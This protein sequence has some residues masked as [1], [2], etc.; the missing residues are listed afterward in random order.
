M[1]NDIIILRREVSGNTRRYYRRIIST[2]YFFKPSY[3]RV[4]YYV[5]PYAQILVCY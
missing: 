4:S 2:F 1:S 3:P 5:T